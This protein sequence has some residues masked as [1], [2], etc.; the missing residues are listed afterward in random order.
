MWYWTTTTAK[1]KKS[2]SNCP[3]ACEWNKD[4]S[5]SDQ[6]SSKKKVSFKLIIKRLKSMIICDLNVWCDGQIGQVLNWFANDR[7]EHKISVN[8]NLKTS[9]KWLIIESINNVKT[10]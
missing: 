5:F 9:T 10:K 2:K 8:A 7:D 3:E 6:L 1:T 4:R